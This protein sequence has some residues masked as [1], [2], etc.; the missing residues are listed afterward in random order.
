LSPA[1]ALNYERVGDFHVSPD[2]GRLAYIQLSY[3]K[4]WLPRI[5]ILDIADGA[6]REIT[7]FQ[8]SERAPE[9][10][11]DGKTLAFLSNR[12]GKVQV[13]AASAQGGAALPLTQHKSA[14][15]A[16]HAW[17][18]LGDDYR[19]AGEIRPPG[20]NMANACHDFGPAICKLPPSAHWVF[21]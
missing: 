17:W 19:G 6:V 12:D 16:F 14:V 15:S 2:G 9:W 3:P 8:K 4:D 20:F 18:R 7:P 13:Y 10:S 5:R 21:V 1:D 11:P